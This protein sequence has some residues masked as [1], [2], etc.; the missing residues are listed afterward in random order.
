VLLVDA[1]NAGMISTSRVRPTFCGIPTSV[2]TSPRKR[3]AVLLLWNQKEFVEIIKYRE[4]PNDKA[5]RQRIKVGG[6]SRHK[7][8]GR[9]YKVGARRDMN[10][11]AGNI[12][13]VA[14]RDINYSGG[15]KQSCRR[16]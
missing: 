8:L 6:G 11:S 9:E 12:K 4:A 5:A 10:Y 7:I 3:T 14:S 16:R 15:N 2:L 1:D 13:L